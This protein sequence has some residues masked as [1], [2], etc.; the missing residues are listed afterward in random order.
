MFNDFCELVGMKLSPQQQAQAKAKAQAYQAAVA[1]KRAR[2]GK[3]AVA[4]DGS[5][6]PPVSLTLD[7]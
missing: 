3:S 1:A 6:E 2:D 7:E 4:G 5:Q